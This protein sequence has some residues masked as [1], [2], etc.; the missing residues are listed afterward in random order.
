[1]PQNA[2]LVRQQIDLLS[3][4]CCGKGNRAT[5]GFV[6]CCPSLK[7]SDMNNLYIKVFGLREK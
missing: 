7:N 1:M 6:G 2:D 3:V 4:K 5:N